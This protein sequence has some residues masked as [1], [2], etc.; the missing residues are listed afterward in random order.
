VEFAI[1]GFAGSDNRSAVPIAEV[2][3]WAGEGI[4][5]YLGET[6]DVRPFIAEADCVVLPSYREGLP[7]S[8]LEASAMGKPMVAT[9]VPGCREIVLDGDTGFLCAAK[10]AQS[11]AEAM[12]AML[13]LSPTER[14]AMGARA[15]RRVEQKF[16]QARVT[17]AYLEALQ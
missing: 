9:D 1:L 12:G 14:A 16:D 15:R 11:L 4:I 13:R 6:E 3:R 17:K 2:K 10:S 7:R 5:A 8:L